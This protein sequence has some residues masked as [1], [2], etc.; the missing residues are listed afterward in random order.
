MPLNVIFRNLAREAAYSNGCRPLSGVRRGCCTPQIYGTYCLQPIYH[1][2]HWLGCH[3]RDICMYVFFLSVF[4]SEYKFVTS[5]V[6]SELK[7]LTGPD[8]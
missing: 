6:N 7:P 8:P 2:D 1:M 3:F 5:Q 4:Y